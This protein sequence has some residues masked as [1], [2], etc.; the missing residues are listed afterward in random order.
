MI[1]NHYDVII[2]GGNIVKNLVIKLDLESLLRKMK[3][4]L[5]QVKRRTIVPF[6]IRYVS[7]I[8]ETTCTM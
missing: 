1:Q 4:H 7:I 3:K 8:K 2:S 6:L 5:K